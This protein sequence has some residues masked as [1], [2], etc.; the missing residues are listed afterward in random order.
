MSPANDLTR[1]ERAEILI[2]IGLLLLL[3][4]GMA[5]LSP[6]W[7]VPWFL[8]FCAAYIRL[9]MVVMGRERSLH[10]VGDGRLQAPG[11]DGAYRG[12]TMLD[13]GEQSR[14]LTDHCDGSANARRVARRQ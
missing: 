5:W 1:L 8:I 14:I 12:V 11:R 4:A 9:V 2:A 10:A 7:R 13:G 6:F 3:L